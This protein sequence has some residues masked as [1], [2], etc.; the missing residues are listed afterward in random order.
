MGV[1]SGVCFPI[2]V[3][4]ELIGTMDF[5]VMR[6][7]QL[8]GARREALRNVGRL[9]S[10]AVT[11]LK[12]ADHARESAQNTAAVNRVL[13]ALA[14]TT[15]VEDAIQTTLEAV[16]NEFGWDYGSYWVCDQ[17][18]GVLRFAF[19]SGA[20]NEEFRQVTRESTFAEGVG[21][22]GRTWRQRDL[23]FVRDIGDMVD[24]SRAPVAKRFGVKSGV[25]FPIIVNGVLVGT[26]DYFVKRSL[27][28]AEE[29]VEALRNVGRLVSGALDRIGRIDRERR[30][31][32]DFQMA[33]AKLSTALTAASSEIGHMN[34]MQSIASQNQATAIAELSAT[35][36]QLRHM[37]I[38]S[39]D[40]AQLVIDLSDRAM[41]SAED[42]RSVVE[43]TVGAMNEIREKVRQLAERIDALSSQSEQIGEIIASVAEIAEQSRLL[44]L[45]AAMEAARAGEH[46]RGFSV[47]ANE[48]RSLASQSKEST[49]QVRKLLGEIRRAT[50]AAAVAMGDGS[51]KVDAGVILAKR[52]GERI[53]VLNR[54]IGEAVDAAR[55][56]ATSARHQGIG[57]SEAA[58]AIRIINNDSAVVV[59]NTQRSIGTV[60]VLNATV[61][62]IAAL[63]DRIGRS[64]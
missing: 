7:L 20:M 6:T 32:S 43:G 37:A 28:L 29:R 64:D 13:A 10:S 62:D 54:F 58:E 46:G 34:T 5:F 49:T 23:L 55:L 33:M 63:V 38:Q 15:S 56:I 53:E 14:A 36:S 35:M 57:V 40:K 42:G 48:I 24:C 52:A 39:N 61:A 26:M 44:A 21:F 2:M 41:K 51:N 3:K 12:A 16:C 18:A 27:D 30:T 1:K 4:D 45:N 60:A 22:N 19:D 47:V 50:D 25:C 17:E 9:V 31:A 59:E 8:S 11:R